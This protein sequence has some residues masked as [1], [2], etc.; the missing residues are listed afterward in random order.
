MADP[1]EGSA[2]FASGAVLG[3]HPGGGLFGRTSFSGVAVFNDVPSAYPLGETVVIASYTRA[4]SSF[5]NVS[6]TVIGSAMTSP[7]TGRQAWLVAIANATD[8]GGSYDV[9]VVRPAD[10]VGVA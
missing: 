3:S 8:G 2:S 4:G 7:P 1:V 9:V 10:L 5:S 6:G